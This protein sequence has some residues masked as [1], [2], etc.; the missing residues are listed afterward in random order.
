MEYCKYAGYVNEK[1]FF[2]VKY[3]LYSHTFIYN[4]IN[5]EVMCKTYESA[6]NPSKLYTKIS[7]E[8]YEIA[9]LLYV[10]QN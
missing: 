9:E 8:E 7:K 10:P 3:N 4:V 6:F 2:Y 1:L 5:G